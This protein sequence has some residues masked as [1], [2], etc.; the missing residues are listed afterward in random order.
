MVWLC[1]CTEVFKV[2]VRHLIAFAEQ[3]LNGHSVK[4]N[5]DVC[6]Q[7]IG[8][9]LRKK[10]DGHSSQLFYLYAS[11]GLKQARIAESVGCGGDVDGANVEFLAAYTNRKISQREFVSSISLLVYVDGSC[12]VA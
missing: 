2:T 5:V 6:M 7:I 9:F 10:V 12:L 3:H 11:V 8:I 4:V 1:A